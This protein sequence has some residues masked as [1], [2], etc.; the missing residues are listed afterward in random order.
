MGGGKDFHVNIMLYSDIGKI[1]ML[2]LRLKS[3]FNL[4][5][6]IK[7]VHTYTE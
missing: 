6:T 4:M 2:N 5:S 7:Q 3:E 1:I